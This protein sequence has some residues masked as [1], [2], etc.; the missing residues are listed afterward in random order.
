MDINTVLFVLKRIHSLILL[1]YIK[2]CGRLYGP[3]SLNIVREICHYLRL[4]PGHLID[5]QGCS[6][7]IYNFLSE[8]WTSVTP[9]NRSISVE[10]S[11]WLYLDWDR[12]VFACGGEC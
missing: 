12:S 2:R 4:F 8:N 5:L 7:R 6:M 1:L 3:L 10:W 9:L 11:R